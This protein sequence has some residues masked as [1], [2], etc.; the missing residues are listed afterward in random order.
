MDLFMKK[1]LSFIFFLLLNFTS[2]HASEIYGL[3]SE[4]INDFNICLKKRGLSFE[5]VNQWENNIYQGTLLNSIY[6]LYHNFNLREYDIESYAENAFNNAIIASGIFYT[7]GYHSFENSIIANTTFVGDLS[8]LNLKNACLVN[9]RFYH[10][11]VFKLLRIEY[12]SDYFKN[13]SE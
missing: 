5:Q 6:P 8:K 2:S 13:V 10:A 12:Q 4:Q 1:L 9:V 11:G 3:N 7:T